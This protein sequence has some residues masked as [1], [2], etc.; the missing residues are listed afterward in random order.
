V[1]LATAWIG[2]GAPQTLFQAEF[3]PV[4]L[5]VIPSRRDRSAIRFA[6]AEIS[7]LIK[8]LVVTD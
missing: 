4:V 3:G 8:D 6:G 5:S 2:L 7:L 1:W